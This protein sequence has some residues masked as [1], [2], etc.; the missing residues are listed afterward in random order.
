M[1]DRR[2]GR[3]K[4]IRIFS[5]G[6]STKWE[7]LCDCGSYCVATTSQL[8]QSEKKSCGCLKKENAS[9]LWIKSVKKNTLPKGQSHFNKLFY[10]C[11]RNASGRNL[12]FD[13]S[14][15]EFKEIIDRNCH[16]CDSKPSLAYIPDRANGGYPHNGIDRINNLIGYEASNCVPCC[17][18]C[19]RMKWDMDYHDFLAHCVTISLTGKTNGL[20]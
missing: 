15:S 3:L 10:Q 4:V 9:K 18:K 16:Y 11:K 19:N 17:N 5:K 1:V 14:E 2:F 13:L 20:N 8:T 6:H 12:I 7:C